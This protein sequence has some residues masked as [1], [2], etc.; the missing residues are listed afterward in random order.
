MKFRE[1]RKIKPPTFDGEMRRNEEVET[2]LLG[3]SKYFQIY[4]YSNNFKAKMATYNLNGKP[5]IWWNDL[6]LVSHISEKRLSWK[7]IEKMFKQKYL[8]KQYFD[9]KI[10]EFHELKL[11]QLNMQDF[12]NNLLK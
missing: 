4:D 2:W 10:K 3:M 12:S 5:S 1:F 11:G 9:R 6:K 8:S 7:Q